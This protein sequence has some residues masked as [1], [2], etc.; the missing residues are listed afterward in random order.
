MPIY[1]YRC[2]KCGCEQEHIV[3]NSEQKVKCKECG[4]KKLERKFPTGTNFKLVG[5]GWYGTGG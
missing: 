1:E 4:S 5:R 3:K 2:D